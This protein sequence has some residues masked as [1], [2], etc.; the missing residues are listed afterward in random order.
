MT[1]AR[2]L[3]AILKN[4]ERLLVNQRRNYGW[5]VTSGSYYTSAMLG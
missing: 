3:A 1:T 4:A 5:T 2:S